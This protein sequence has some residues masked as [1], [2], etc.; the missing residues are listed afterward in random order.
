MLGFFSLN[1]MAEPNF[2]CMM[3]LILYALFICRI[4]YAIYRNKLR[5]MDKKWADTEHCFLYLLGNKSV[6][7]IQGKKECNQANEWVSSLKS[8]GLELAGVFLGSEFSF[9]NV[10]KGP[11]QNTFAYFSE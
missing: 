3:I 4:T 9:I 11:C 8:S 10:L 1:V 2:R 7:F 6:S 5:N